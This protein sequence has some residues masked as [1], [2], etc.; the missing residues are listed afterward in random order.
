MMH[1]QGNACLYQQKVTRVL[2]SSWTMYRIGFIIADLRSVI[3]ALVVDRKE[4]DHVDE[5]KRLM[6]QSLKPEPQ[7]VKMAAQATTEQ[8]Q[9]KRNKKSKVRVV[10]LDCDDVVEKPATAFSNSVAITIPPSGSTPSLMLQ[11]TGSSPSVKSVDLQDDR[12]LESKRPAMNLSEM[13]QML[14]DLTDKKCQLEESKSSLQLQLHGVQLEKQDLQDRFKV[15]EQQNME[16][17]RFD[18]LFS[19]P[20]NV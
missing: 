16:V 1:H 11:Q 19:N 18:E 3:F 2:T 7:A 8:E 17:L 6:I 14:L 4:L 13:K 5:L 9:T 15:V 20:N 10:D 12:L